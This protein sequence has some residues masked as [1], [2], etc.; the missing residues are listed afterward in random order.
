ML[1]YIQTSA[2]HK[3]CGEAAKHLPSFEGT[4]A[5]KG[6]NIYFQIIL[7]ND[8]PEPKLVKLKDCS[9]TF[10]EIF[11]NKP[12]PVL[13]SHYECDHNPHYISDTPFIPDCLIPLEP[14]DTIIVGQNPVFLWVCTRG[15][16]PNV[17]DV[18]YEFKTE[19]E[20]LK[21]LFQLKVINYDLPKR[22]MPITAAISPNSIAC[23]ENVPLFS[24]VFWDELKKHFHLQNYD[25][26]LNF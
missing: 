22:A 14:M 6:E 20:V 24:N 8:D 15:H 25:F 10:G 2:L 26:Q 16:F 21:T 3:V 13:F 7:W 4:R 11:L 9:N 19:S 12:V 1:H 23:S 5:L 18:S 17:Y